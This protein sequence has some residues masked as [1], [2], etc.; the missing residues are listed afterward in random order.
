MAIYSAVLNVDFR[1]KKKT[2]TIGVALTL[3]VMYLYACER[4]SLAYRDAFNSIN[5]V[6]ERD[7]WL[8]MELQQYVQ[9]RETNA[10]FYS[11]LNFRPD[12]EHIYSAVPNISNFAF[13]VTLLVRMM[14]PT[15]IVLRVRETRDGVRTRGGGCLYG[16]VDSGLWRGVCSFR[17]SF[18][19]DYVIWCRRPAAGCTDVMVQV[20]CV[21]FGAYSSVH[22]ALNRTI[23]RKTICAD[24]SRTLSELSTSSARLLATLEREATVKNAVR[25][26]RQTLHDA[27]SPSEL[28]ALHT[29]SLKEQLCR[30]V[31]RFDQI[32]L[33][34]SSHMR[35]K[36]DFFW[37]L[38]LSGTNQMP[39]KHSSSSVGNIMY[40][41]RPVVHSFESMRHVE[42]T[43]VSLTRDSL[44]ILQTGTHDIVFSGLPYTM[45]TAV[46][47]FID[48][49][50]ELK[51]MSDR[52]GFKLILQTMPPSPDVNMHRTKG[53]RNNFA[54]AAFVQLLT[55]RLEKLN[56]DIFDEFNALLRMQYDNVCGPH[57]ICR[58]DKVKPTRVT[59]HSGK[60][61]LFLQMSKI[62]SLA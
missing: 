13:T 12:K 29:D 54:V 62:C 61:V 15:T 1:R 32:V 2:I 36:F 23:W 31:K 19:G 8:P 43:N 47:R 33:M 44:M 18:D 49:L 50:R 40:K 46:D 39:R 55:F 48:I 38:C 16:E 35:Y 42:I 58:S 6:Y 34:G 60:M 41:N 14:T 25:W 20:Q 27:W 51:E 17:D 37:E 10:N 7:D 3:L 30:C 22:G 5:V 57:Y 52:I 11:F 21:D 56:I 45:E 24:K 28:L 53:G 9:F 26:R 59:G 4:A